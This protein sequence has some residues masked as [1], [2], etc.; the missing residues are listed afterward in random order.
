MKENQL[1][2]RFDPACPE[3]FWKALSPPETFA[4]LSKA[5]KVAGPWEERAGGSYTSF[6]RV[7]ATPE[8]E[9]TYAAVV[10]SYP[11]SPE[12][13]LWQAGVGFWENGDDEPDHVF[14]HKGEGS[15]KEEAQAAADNCLLHEDRVTWVLVDPVVPKK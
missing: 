14:G 10:F 4:L 2:I 9:P 6:G 15:T 3:D 8:D 1:I 7:D 11:G 12:K 5:P 13:W